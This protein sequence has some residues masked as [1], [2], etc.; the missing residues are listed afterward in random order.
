MHRKT[1]S[2]TP[3]VCSILHFIQIRRLTEES[4]ADCRG[5]WSTPLVS[6]SSDMAWLWFMMNCA[7]A[8]Y[9]PLRVRL[10]LAARDHGLQLG[11]NASAYGFPP[12]LHASLELIKMHVCVERCRPNMHAGPPEAPGAQI[13]R[14]FDVVVAL[15]CILSGS[16]MQERVALLHAFAQCPMR[17]TKLTRDRRYLRKCHARRRTEF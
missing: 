11:V 8:G 2:S 6:R 7:C 17:T 9:N 4:L 5:N 12:P 15:G 13:F 10:A 16:N 14:E 3:A 1:N